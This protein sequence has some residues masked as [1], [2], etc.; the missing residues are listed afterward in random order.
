MY[1][2]VLLVEEIKDR[3]MKF[4]HRKKKDIRRDKNKIKTKNKIDI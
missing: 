1:I 3:Y 2:S 4:G